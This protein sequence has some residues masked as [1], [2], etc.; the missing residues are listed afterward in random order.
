MVEQKRVHMRLED[1][2]E[3]E[4][5]SEIAGVTTIMRTKTRDI[6]AG[7]CKVFLSQRL[8]K[9]E[10]MQLKMF[11]PGRKI[12]IEAEGEVISSDLIAVVLDSGEQK[13]YETRFKFGKIDAA[14]KR[15]IINY[16]YE[17]RRKKYTL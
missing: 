7:G 4:F 11:L 13:L 10:R 15:E 5:S 14:A 6:S 9:G 12:R 1:L 8:S 2:V 3:V 17:C 16:V